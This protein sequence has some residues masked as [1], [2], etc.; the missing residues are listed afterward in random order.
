MRIVPKPRGGST[1]RGLFK[2]SV[3]SEA[4]KTIS[5][6]AMGRKMRRF[7]APLPRNR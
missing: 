3:S 6:V 1:P 5:G 7:V 4:P 2:K